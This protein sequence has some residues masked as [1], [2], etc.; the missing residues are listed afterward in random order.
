MYRR[1]L[2][3]APPPPAAPTIVAQRAAAIPTPLTISIPLKIL[4]VLNLSILRIL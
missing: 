2:R 1:I 3:T 4:S